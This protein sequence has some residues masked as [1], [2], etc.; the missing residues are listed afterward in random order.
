MKGGI[1]VAE[2]LKI[3][4]I[5]DFLDLEEAA[6]ESTDGTF[7]SGEG[8]PQDGPQN[9]EEPG[10]AGGPA[11]AAP[12]EGGTGDSTD[13]GGPASSDAEPTPPENEETAP[14]ESGGEGPASND[15]EQTDAT[16]GNTT[17]ENTEAQGDHTETEESEEHMQVVVAEPPTEPAPVS[18]PSNGSLVWTLVF[19]LIVL[20]GAGVIV[21]FL[22]QKKHQKTTPKP[23]E[24]EGK[25]ETVRTPA[26]SDRPRIQCSMAQT[27]G[28]RSEQQDSLYCSSWTDQSILES[29][30]LLAAVADGIGG[31][32]NGHLASRGAIE[33]MRAQ[34]LN[35]ASNVSPTETLLNLSASAQKKV[36]EL[37]EQGSH[38]GCTLV[39]V[40]LKKWEMWFLSIGDSHIYLY[41]AGSMLQL[42]REHTLGRQNAEAQSFGGNGET[43]TAKRAGALTSY[44]GKK[45]LTLID[46]SLQ[47]MRVMPG[48]RILLMSD[49]VFNTL[50]DEEIMAC[51][52]GS[53][54]KAAEAVIQKVEA[55]KKTSQDNASV[56]VI[57]IE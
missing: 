36:L 37:N 57:G 13:A 56:V 46:R 23:A 20:A 4:T 21:F 35:Q 49:G 52:R 18:Q 40:L 39:T 45:D 32:D 55:H 30:G 51:V 54:A 38:C 25:T 43:L 48:D 50:S 12:G 1:L 19:L 27:I 6:P 22:R 11:D 29:R 7:H 31:I 24:G 33:A 2:D 15:N 26:R 34:F 28:T 10:N 44:L 53:T 9:K 3:P 5:Q 14:G 8:F 17:G 16:E 42:N 41:R 47:P